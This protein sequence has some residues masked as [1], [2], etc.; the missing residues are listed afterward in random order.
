MTLPVFLWVAS[1]QTLKYDGHRVAISRE[2][3]S[4]NEEDPRTEV[5][6]AGDENAGKIFALLEVRAIDVYHCMQRIPAGL[7]RQLRFWR[8]VTGDN[9]HGRAY[10]FHV[11]RKLKL[12]QPRDLQQF[13]SKRFRTLLV[14]LESE[15]GPALWSDP[16]IVQASNA[17]GSWLG[18]GPP[19]LA[20]RM[21]GPFIH[22]LLEDSCGD[23]P[24]IVLPHLRKEGSASASL[25]I[26]WSLLGGPNIVPSMP[27]H[28]ASLSR[29]QQGASVLDTSLVDFAIDCL[30]TYAESLPLP[31]H[32]LGDME[33]EEDPSQCR[34]R[35]GSEL[36]RDLSI[37]S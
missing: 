31:V 30:Q 16:A 10:I 9:L 34:I 21:P 18:P 6:S 3:C 20:L 5:Q 33:Q 32:A 36:C 28:V 7:K 8:Q 22:K 26:N 14:Q 2:A 35:S 11:S 17:E 4:D 13:S 29:P 1:I 23:W 15:Q 25:T 37:S 12:D 19:G 24:A 27:P